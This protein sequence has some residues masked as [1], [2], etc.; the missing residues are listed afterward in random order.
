MEAE[1]KLDFWPGKG[2]EKEGRAKGGRGKLHQ[3]VSKATQK[4]KADAVSS[5][6]GR[7]KSW[8]WVERARANPGSARS[9]VLR[10][11]SYLFLTC[12]VV[13]LLVLGLQR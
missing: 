5:R 1:R 9:R 2:G 6:R 7:E 12:L 11:C 4:S 8:V 13:I 3:S 10:E